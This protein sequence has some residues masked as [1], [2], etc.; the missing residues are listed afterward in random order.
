MSPGL[1]GYVRDDL[2]GPGRGA[3]ARGGDPDHPIR[4]GFLCTKVLRSIGRVYGKERVEGPAA[5]RAFEV[6][7]KD[8]PCLVTM[9]S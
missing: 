6:T 2:H 5:V 4:Q 9:P 3:G 7:R 8:L 1:S